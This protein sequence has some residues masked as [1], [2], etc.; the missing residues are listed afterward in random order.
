MLIPPQRKF[1]EGGVK[2]PGWFN[3][4][5]LFMIF[6]AAIDARHGPGFLTPAGHGKRS[7]N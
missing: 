7:E 2:T 6:D 1:N 4:G 5:V 3:V